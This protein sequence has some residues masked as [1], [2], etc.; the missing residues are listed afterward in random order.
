MYAHQVVEDYTNSTKM[1]LERQ[2][3]M[4]GQ[5]V[6]VESIFLK[7]ISEAIHYHFG[8]IAQ[9]EA[10]VKTDDLFTGEY[11]EDVRLPFNACWFDYNVGQAKAG[12][13]LFEM[14]K[15]LLHVE[16][17]VYMQKG[18]MWVPNPYEVFVGL[19]ET[20]EKII[21]ENNPRF[22]NKMEYRPLTQNIWIIYSGD[23]GAN[24]ISKETVEPVRELPELKEH[25]RCLNMCLLLLTCKN[26][27]SEINKAPAKLNK[28][29]ALKNKGPLFDYRTLK[30]ILPKKKGKGPG[31]PGT[32]QEKRMHLCQGHFRTYTDDAPLFGKLTGRF[33]IPAHI[34]GNEETGV[35][36]KDYHVSTRV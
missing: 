24:L 30:L 16:L 29:R 4:F 3:N 7:K 5:E 11:G 15:N 36:K 18:K 17:F 9:I 8:D 31:S 21:E 10:M 14:A 20:V 27:G 6:V 34:R 19:G 25:L 2:K 12:F 13:F 32:E 35:V 23:Q 26:I 28:K 33:W 1:M 22:A